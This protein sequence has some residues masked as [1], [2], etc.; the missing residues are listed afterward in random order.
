MLMKSDDKLTVLV[1]WSKILQIE[2]RKVIRFANKVMTSVLLFVTLK[3]ISTTMAGTLGSGNVSD[4]I[5][6]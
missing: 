5:F 4:G 2:M 3:L 1:G 6:L